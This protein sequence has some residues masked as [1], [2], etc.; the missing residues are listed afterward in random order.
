[1]ISKVMLTMESRIHGDMY[2]R[3]EGRLVETYHRKVEKHCSPSLLKEIAYVC[4]IHKNFSTHTA[5][6]SYAT[7]VCLQTIK[8]INSVL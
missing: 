8:L 6:H 7:T 1:M 3:F 5:R 2:V 4:G